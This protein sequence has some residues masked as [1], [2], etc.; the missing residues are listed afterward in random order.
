[1]GRTVQ[2]SVPDRHSP[3]WLVHRQGFEEALDSRALAS[4]LG[5]SRGNK[6]GSGWESEWVAP[7]ERVRWY[8]RLGAQ[9]EQRL[10]G[11]AGWWLSGTLHR[12][13]SR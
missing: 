7:S 1:M 5:L 6:N 12:P 9:L 4:E 3:G 13:M 11:E 8:S 10:G 2:T